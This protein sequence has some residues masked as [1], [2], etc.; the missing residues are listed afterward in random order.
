MNSKEFLNTKMGGVIELILFL[1]VAIAPLPMMLSV[2]LLIGIAIMSLIVK[3]TEW[4]EIGFSFKDFSFKKIGI[5]LL[6]A[7]VYHYIDEYLMDPI[8]SKYT[9]SGLPE[10]FSMKGNV[11]KLIIGLTLSWTTAAFFEEILFRGYL[12][13]RFI[14][15][16]G[17]SFLSKLAIIILTGTVFGFVHVYQGMHGAISAGIIG[18]FQAIVFFADGKKL[19]I[20]III[21]GAFDTIG[22]TLMFLG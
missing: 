1:I 10:I 6:I 12:I 8:I 15:V 20:P 14:D 11:T 22:F 9:P 13:S 18:V 7:I 5:G 3:D 17:Q 19:A 16:I 2:P 21:H 4:I